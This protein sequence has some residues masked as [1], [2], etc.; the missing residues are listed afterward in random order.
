LSLAI[1]ELLNDL[2]A[3]ALETQN[4]KPDPSLRFP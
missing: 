2:G 3:S 4:H 1:L